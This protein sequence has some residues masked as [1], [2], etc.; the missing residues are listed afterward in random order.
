MEELLQTVSRIGSVKSSV[1]PSL[2]E[3]YPCGN[4]TT[5]EFQMQILAWNCSD[6]H[7]DAEFSVFGML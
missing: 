1:D 5:L 7:S 4:Q 6:N 3:L 2:S